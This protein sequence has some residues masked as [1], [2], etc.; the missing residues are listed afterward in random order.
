[1]GFTS[2]SSYTL[3]QAIILCNAQNNKWVKLEKMEKKLILGP[4]LVCLA[5]ILSPLDF[6]SASS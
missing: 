2:N 4:I 5:Q 1:M 3:F 6:T